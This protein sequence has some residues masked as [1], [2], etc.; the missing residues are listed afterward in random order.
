MP[1]NFINGS[2]S[3]WATR[4]VHLYVTSARPFESDL[5]SE[6]YFAWLDQEERER[7]K[8]FSHTGARAQYLCG[9]AILKQVLCRYLDVD[10]TQVKFEKSENGKLFLP[11]A[12]SRGLEFNMTHKP[13]A[14]ACAVAAG[15]PVGVDLELFKPDKTGEKIAQRFFSDAE[16]EFLSEYTDASYARRFFQL[17]TLK[18]AYIKALG[19]GMKLPLKQFSLIPRCELEAKETA[20]IDVAFDSA[21]N[22]NPVN[23]QFNLRSVGDDVIIA[24]ALKRGDKP[25]LAVQVQDDFRFE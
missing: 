18:E 15:V 13:G 17:W 20:D 10:P 19:L 1:A 9:R 5:G 6:K 23:W 11:P 22:E 25:D 24:L 21:L 14:V 3:F 8:R 12:A 16:I 2:E 7:F 4:E